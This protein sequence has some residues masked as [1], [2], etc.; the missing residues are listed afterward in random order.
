[1]PATR[2]SYPRRQPSPVRAV[3][4]SAGLVILGPRG[5]RE[6]ANRRR[7][8]PGAHGS[9]ASH[10]AGRVSVPAVPILFSDD[11][12]RHARSGKQV[13]AAAS[14][15]GAAPAAGTLASSAYPHNTSL[16][17]VGFQPARRPLAFGATTPQRAGC[18]S[19]HGLQRQ[20]TAAGTATEAGAAISS[21]SGT[22]TEAGHGVRFRGRSRSWTEPL[23]VPLTQRQRR[24]GTIPLERTRG[25]VG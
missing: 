12:L 15:S 22:A 6:A 19:H 4:C 24:S 18:P 1:M 21:G 2:P 10:F 8:T 11:W 16:G 17:G 23:R 5:G 3:S 9:G 14:D 13:T 20:R 25:P 7:R